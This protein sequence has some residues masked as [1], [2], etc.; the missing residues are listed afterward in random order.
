MD[1]SVLN[2]YMMSNCP[3]EPLSISSIINLFHGDEKRQ[4]HLFH[5]SSD[6]T[7]YIQSYSDSKT[8]T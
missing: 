3:R 7:F 8:F 1:F 6:D 5:F 4:A 2:M